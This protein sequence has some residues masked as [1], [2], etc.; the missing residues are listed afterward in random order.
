M[1]QFSQN[2]LKPLFSFS[3]PEALQSLAGNHLI[4]KTTMKVE[5]YLQSFPPKRP[6]YPFQYGEQDPLLTSLPTDAAAFYFR[7][8][9]S[10]PI[11]NRAEKTVCP[12]S[13]TNCV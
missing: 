8:T 12:V 13:K 6:M 5:L 1:H 4:Q 10:R 7:F 2:R 9:G 11:E 3:V